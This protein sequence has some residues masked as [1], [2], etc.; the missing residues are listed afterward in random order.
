MDK[1]TRF[2]V[3]DDDALNNKICR[4]CIEKL[5]K[6]TPVATFIDP[7]AG[8]EHIESEYSSAA[9]DDNCILFLDINMPTMTGWE[10][11]DLFDKLDEK[12]KN[13]VKIY[14]LSSSVDKRDMERAQANKNVVYYLIKPLTKET[15]ALITYAQKKK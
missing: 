3:I 6:D 2:V 14:I 15:I 5:Y 4:A 13:R 9:H 10:F 8:F 7:K 12:I 1:S 11:L